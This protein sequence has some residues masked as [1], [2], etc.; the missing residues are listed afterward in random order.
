MG[1]SSATPR[2]WR[3]VLDVSSCHQMGR[4]SISI[5]ISNT[6]IIMI[7]IIIVIWQ[8]CHGTVATPGLIVHVKERVKRFELHIR[9]IWS[10]R[11]IFPL[12]VYCWMIMRLGCFWTSVALFCY[13]FT[14]KCE[15]R[16][17]SD[18]LWNSLRLRLI[19]VVILLYFGVYVYT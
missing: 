15:L 11:I 9:S 3:S 12:G 1:E 19:F 17:L 5:S 18:A 4:I 7:I 13:L 16:C 8:L 2:E 10:Y 6:I 14:S